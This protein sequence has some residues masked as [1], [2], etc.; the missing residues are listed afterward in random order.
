MNTFDKNTTASM[1]I[2][3]Q[4]SF[5]PLCPDE[6]PVPDGHNIVDALNRQA[7]WA[8]YRVGSKDWHPANALWLATKES[9]QFTPIVN[10]KNMNM[11]WNAHCIA[12]TRG[13]ELLDGLPSVSDYD[14]MVYKGLEPDM[15]PYGACYHDLENKISTGLIEFLKDKGVTR[16]ICGGLA[17]DFCVN[18]TA[19]QLS[20]HFEV[21]VNLS[22]CRGIGDSSDAIKEMV[23]HGIKVD[24]L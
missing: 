22:A 18:M 16:V 11:H 17:T 23:E 5:T 19:I 2:D 12:G 3:C 1:D 7:K 13:A 24:Y 21:W 14:F 10:A 4:R 15:H 8:R 9:P 6:L 20:K